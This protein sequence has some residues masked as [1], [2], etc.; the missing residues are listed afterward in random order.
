MDA[1]IRR[2]GRPSIPTNRYVDKVVHL[3]TRAPTAG[4]PPRKKQAKQPR[5]ARKARKCFN[6][7]LAELENIEREYIQTDPEIKWKRGGVD[8]KHIEVGAD[9][10]PFWEF[11]GFDEMGEEDNDPDGPIQLGLY[12]PDPELMRLRIQCV[13]AFEDALDSE[14]TRGDPAQLLALESLLIDNTHNAP[15]K[16]WAGQPSSSSSSSSSSTTPLPAADIVC[17]HTAPEESSMEVQD[18]GTTTTPP[19]TSSSSSYS[20]AIPHRE[21]DILSVYTV[22]VYTISDESSSSGGEEMQDD[23]DESV[24]SVDSDTRI[25]KNRTALA[26]LD[27]CE[28]LCAH[29]GSQLDDHRRR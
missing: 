23:D 11:R 15:V 22:S 3:P 4:Q 1:P 14:S 13:A 9:D 24:V 20:S 8:C 29:F 2:S 6:E 25:A 26:K 16:G 5:P 12:T 28:D 18:D 10:D 21:P 27:T 17:G 19:A 7:L